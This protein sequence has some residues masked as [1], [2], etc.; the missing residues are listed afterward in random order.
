M[1]CLIEIDMD[2][3]AFEDNPGE[4]AN[5]LEALAGQIDVVGMYL[6]RSIMDGN[7]NKVGMVRFS[8]E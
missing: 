5:I 6:D 4:L 2:N 8:L 3:A 1:K 7:G